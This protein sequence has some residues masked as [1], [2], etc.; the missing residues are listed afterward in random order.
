MDFCTNCGK[1]LDGGAFCSGCGAKVEPLETKET[2]FAESRSNQNTS[3]IIVGLAAVLVIISGIFLFK[4]C[5]GGYKSTLNSYMNAYKAGDG[6]KILSLMPEKLSKKQGNRLNFD[7]AL[8]HAIEVLDAYNGDISKMDYEISGKIDLYE[9]E[10]KDIK[11]YYREQYGISLDIS[12]AVEVEI[13]VTIPVEEEEVTK[14]FEVTLAK[15]EGKWYLLESNL[16]LS[17]FYKKIKF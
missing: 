12:K 9:D 11:K 7:N 17:R 10:I 8:D 3:P 15:I 14:E 2:S 4:S 1:E 6:I 16:N 5:G 13:E